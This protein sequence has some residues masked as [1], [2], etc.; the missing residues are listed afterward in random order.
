MN[1]RHNKRNS[2]RLCHFWGVIPIRFSS[3]IRFNRGSS[4]HLH[5]TTL[6]PKSLRPCESPWVGKIL[7]ATSLF[8]TSQLRIS[9]NSGS[10]LEKVISIEIL[11]RESTSQNVYFSIVGKKSVELGCYGV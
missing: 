4:P 8:A 5:L 1:L 7:K 3:S 2:D 10:L 11:M 9:A 6:G